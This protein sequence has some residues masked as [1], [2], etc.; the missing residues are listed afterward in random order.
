MQILIFSLKSKLFHRS[1]FIRD[2]LAIDNFTGLNDMTSR[3]VRKISKYSMPSKDRSTCADCLVEFKS[4]AALD[5]H[6]CVLKYDPALEVEID[7]RSDDDIKAVDVIL[8]DSNKAAY[9]CLKCKKVFKTLRGCNVHISHCQLA[10]NSISEDSPQKLTT[11]IKRTVPKAQR[12]MKNLHPSTSDVEDS[13]Q[14]LSTPIKGPVRKAQRKMKYLHP[15]T[16]D[17]EDSTQKLPTPIKSSVRKV[18]RKMKCLDPSTSDSDQKCPPADRSRFFKRKDKQYV[19]SRCPQMCTSMNEYRKHVKSHKTGSLTSALIQDFSSTNVVLTTTKTKVVA[20][21][22]ISNGHECPNCQQ[23]FRK[24]GSYRRHLRSH[25]NIHSY[26]CKHCLI[27]F[28]SKPQLVAHVQQIHRGEKIYTCSVEDCNKKFFHSIGF[29][30]HKSEHMSTPPYQCFRC[31]AVFPTVAKQIIHITNH[32]LAC[33]FCRK[34]FSNDEELWLHTT[35]EH[36]E[37]KEY[38]D[39]LSETSDCDDND[40][41]DESNANFNEVD[42]ESDADSFTSVESDPEETRSKRVSICSPNR[43]QTKGHVCFIC[44]RR[45]PKQKSLDLHMKSHKIHSCMAC[46]KFFADPSELKAHQQEHL[47]NNN[48]FYSK[49]FNDLQLSVQQPPSSVLT[50]VPVDTQSASNSSGFSSQTS[51]D[52]ITWYSGFKETSKFLK[53]P[54]GFELYQS[55]NQ[56]IADLASTLY[57]RANVPPELRNSYIKIYNELTGII[58]KNAEHLL[59]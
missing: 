1:V 5:A 32:T 36:E 35:A 50:V 52:F 54:I 13:P 10:A 47:K 25:L 40:S 44:E 22:I 31:D 12:K 33:S 30:K 37:D 43:G 11:F 53:Y 49:A 42:V 59:A 4:K 6:T 14:K 8:T 51:T 7:A 41:N 46:P 3:S 27:S 24:I 58:A 21:N 17:A 39:F 2:D 20:E 15:S 23:K 9:K 19:C 55:I 57:N 29:R 45:F 18:Q 38:V 48:F 16:S 56:I 26:K 34:P 28:L